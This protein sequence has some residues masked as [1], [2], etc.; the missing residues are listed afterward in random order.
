MIYSCK[1][2]S[3]SR[4]KKLCFIAQKAKCVASHPLGDDQQLTDTTRLTATGVACGGKPSSSPD[5]AGGAAQPS[6]TARA[7]RQNAARRANTTD[8][9]QP[10]CLP[11]RAGVPVLPRILSGPTTTRF[12][13]SYAGVLFGLRFRTRTAARANARSPFA[14]E[15]PESLHRA[16]QIQVPEHIGSTGP[17]PAQPS[18]Q[19]ASDRSTS[20]PVTLPSRSRISASFASLCG[21]VATG[22]AGSVPSCANCISSRSS[23]GFP[24]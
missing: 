14:A 13:R 5:R 21:T 3:Q 2:I 20:R 1:D 19:A 11:P 12:R 24:T 18:Y 23:F 8:Q 4:P 10:P 17:D 9:R 22:N 15:S 6:P 7:N 16:L